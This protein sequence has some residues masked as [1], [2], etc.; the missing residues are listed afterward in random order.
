MPHNDPIIVIDTAPSLNALETAVEEFIDYGSTNAVETWWAT[1]S[2]QA[3][4]DLASLLN[5]SSTNPIL[6][7]YSGQKVGDTVTEITTDIG[8]IFSTLAKG[9]NQT[10]D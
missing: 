6:L 10:W 4:D 8:D 5:S 1:Q 3:L 7:G 9:A 2:G